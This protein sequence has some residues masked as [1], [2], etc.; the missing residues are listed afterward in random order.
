MFY[1]VT[2]N[3]L[4]FESNDP[5]SNPDRTFTQPSFFIFIFYRLILRLPIIGF[6]V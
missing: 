6:K 1:V 4:D 3:I 2:V 5:G